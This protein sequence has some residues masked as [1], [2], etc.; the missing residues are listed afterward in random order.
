M[1]A[2]TGLITRTIVIASVALVL[3]PWAGGTG[4]ALAQTDEQEEAGLTSETSY[5]SPE[6]GFEVE[7]DDPWEVGD[8]FPTTER[9]GPDQLVL[10]GEPREEM[11][12]QITVFAVASEESP[13]DLLESVTGD[14]LDDED[15]YPDAE[16]V[17]EHYDAE[18]PSATISWLFE[19]DRLI[20]TTEVRVI[21][22]GESVLVV[23][24]WVPEEDFD[25]AF[26]E[27]NEV[28]SLDGDPLFAVVGDE[29]DTDEDDADEQASE[30]EVEPVFWGGAGHTGAQPGPGPEGDLSIAWSIELPVPDSG[31]VPYTSPVYA[32]GILYVVRDDGL[33]A[34]EADGGDELWHYAA[35]ANNGDTPAV[36]GGAVFFASYD[37]IFAVAAD[38]GDL[39]WQAEGEGGDETALAAADG[40][41]HVNSD[42]RLVAFD[43]ETGEEIWRSH[44]G[45]FKGL[46]CTP[47]VVDGVV[48][49]GG[50]LQRDGEQY[51][52]LRALDAE[53]G[54]EL[55]LIETAIPLCSPPAVSDGVVY[56]TG[57][58]DYVLFAFDAE[59]GDDLWEFELPASNRPVPAV[60]NGLVYIGDAE[61]TLT[62]LDAATGDV[63]WDT[64]LDGYVRYPVVVGDVVYA[65]TS[66]T[67]V[68]LDGASGEHLAEVGIV[69]AGLFGS[70]TIATS[71]VVVDGFVYLTT[72]A[73]LVAIEGAG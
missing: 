3:A 47:T 13:D 48:Y 35:N 16:L 5:E 10:Y 57:G 32:D 45:A 56:A 22:E 72:D 50:Q 39:L 4:I 37:G 46:H 33:H 6:F 67:L 25:D 42:G 70:G 19:G 21:E 28:V 53:S 40:R 51:P 34:V 8:D 43:A 11:R 17:E 44:N 31:P 2:R 27:I 29:L 55:W 52:M 26:A 64:G 14:R 69:E 23:E 71:P 62:A 9:G 68:V 61:G 58:D 49:A 15:E 60:A 36:A 38:S 65:F 24:H 20:Q 54:D 1:G 66:T 30:E 18:P 63:V 73:G 59:S 12:D 41:V 7:W